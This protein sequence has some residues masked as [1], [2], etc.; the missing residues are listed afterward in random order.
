MK[1][2]PRSNIL[3]TLVLSI[4]LIPNPLLTCSEELVYALISSPNSLK[5][6][7][8][9]SGTPDLSPG[10]HLRPIN[11]PKPCGGGTDGD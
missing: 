3:G 1:I 2:L 10:L 11:A 7:R 5:K 6:R 8:L 9:T 4:L